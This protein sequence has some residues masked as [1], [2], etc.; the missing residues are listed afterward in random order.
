MYLYLEVGGGVVET[1]IPVGSPRGLISMITMM[2]MFNALAMQCDS[3]MA[4]KE[5]ARTAKIWVSMETASTE[6][7]FA[8]HAR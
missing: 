1:W 8:K 6:C 7:V 2:M 5:S 3:F 4:N